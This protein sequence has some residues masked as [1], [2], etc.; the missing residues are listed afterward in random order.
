[1]MTQVDELDSERH[2][3]MTFCEFVEA[4]VRIAEQTCIPH[5]VSDPYTFD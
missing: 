5:L 3:N 4:I 1:M 2:M